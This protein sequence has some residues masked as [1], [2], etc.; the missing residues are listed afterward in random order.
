MALGTVKNVRFY[1]NRHSCRTSL[2]GQAAK[3]LRPRLE[4]LNNPKI[5]CVPFQNQRHLADGFIDEPHVEICLDF[6]QIE[7]DDI[8]SSLAK[9]RRDFAKN[10]Q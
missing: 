6:G 10:P 2:L 7:R 3:S 5:D 4:Y 9:K 8:F 1:R